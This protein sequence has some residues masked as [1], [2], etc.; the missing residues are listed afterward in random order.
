MS[1]M[2]MILFGKALSDSQ[3]SQGRG[4]ALDTCM[5]AFVYGQIAMDV[6]LDAGAC[7]FLI[8]RCCLQSHRNSFCCQCSAATDWHHIH[9]VRL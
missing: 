5:S 4:D 6:D 1:W 2:M 8:G 7:Y 3:N 9:T